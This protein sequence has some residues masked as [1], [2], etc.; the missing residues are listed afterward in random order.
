MK[1]FLVLILIVAVLVRIIKTQ[2]A[3]SPNTYKAN[4]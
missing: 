2:L 1:Y 3:A 4:S